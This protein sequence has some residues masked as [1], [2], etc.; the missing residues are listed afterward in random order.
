MPFVCFASLP[1]KTDKKGG[2]GSHPPPPLE[3]NSRFVGTIGPR[4]YA[5]ADL[6]GQRQKPLS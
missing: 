2:R 3:G 4:L 1:A 5:C 6:P